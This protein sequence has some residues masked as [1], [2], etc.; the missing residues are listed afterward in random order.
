MKSPMQ[1]KTCPACQ[2]LAIRTSTP[3]LV[4][5]FMFNRYAALM[6][7]CR[8]F[9]AE[10]ELNELRLS[11]HCL[12]FLQNLSYHGFVIDLFARLS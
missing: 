1:S 7:N 12:F 9:C 3:K 2:K 4:Q 10:E 5:R 8:L 6:L 11:F